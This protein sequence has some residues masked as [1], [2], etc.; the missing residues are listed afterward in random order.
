MR[1]DDDLL[2]MLDSQI[3]RLGGVGQAIWEAAAASVPLEQLADNVGRVHGRHEGYRIAVEAAAEQL[4]GAT[5][6]LERG[7]E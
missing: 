7:G 1:V 5:V 3:V 4:V 6:V 2:V